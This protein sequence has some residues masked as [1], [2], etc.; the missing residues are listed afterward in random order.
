M[1]DERRGHAEF[2]RRR[3][4]LA[5]ATAL[6]GIAALNLTTPGQTTTKTGAG[7]GA[8][9]GARR[10]TLHIVGH[11]HIDAA[12]LWPWRDGSNVVL[13]TIR[14]ALDRMRETPDFRYSHSSTAHYEWVER[15]DPAMFAEI[16]ERV[17]EGRWELVGGWPVEPD[18]NIP[19]TESLVRHC[20]YGKSYFQRAFGVDVQIGFN[21]DSF[22][23]PAG[24]PSILRRAG[25]RYYVF[26]RPQEHELKLPLLFWWE[27]PDGSR[28]LALRIRRGYSEPAHR[29]RLAAENNFQEGF[30][31][32]AFFLGVGNHGGSV[33]KEQIRQVAEM[34]GDATL[35]EL[36]WS[37]VGEFFKAVE[38]SPA[39]AALP[40]V[41]TELQYHS[42]GVYS[43]HG[44]IKQTN[45][46][47]ERWL[48]QAEAISL[49]AAIGIG[50]RYPSAEYA[51]AWGKVL[52][53]QFH[54]LMAGTAQYVAYRDARDQLGAACDTALTN[55]VEA[56]EAMARRVDTRAVKEGAV[57]AFNP[58]PWPRKCLVE[59]HTERNPGSNP[60][61]PVPAGVVPVTHLEAKD[62]QK[63]PLQFRPSDSMTQVYPRITAWVDLPACGYK[64]FEVAHGTPPETAPYRNFF[65]VNEEGFGISSLKATDG[66]ELLAGPIGLVVIGDPSDT[67][68]HGV[69]K[70][71]AEA[72]RPTFVSTQQVEDGPVTRVIRQRARWRNSEVVLDI[73]QFKAIDAIELRF[74][75]DWHERE[76][77]LKLEVPTAFASP[78]VFAKVPGAAVERPPDG[79]EQP[80]QDWVAVAGRI[81]GNEH[82]LGLIN[83]STYSYDCKGGLLRTILIRAAP[84]ARH[85]PHQVPHNDNGAWQDQGRQERR[86]WLVRGP[87]AFTALELDRLSDEMQTPAEYVMD[88]AHGGSEPW[89]RSF[90]RLSPGNV[91]LLSL[92]RAEGGEGS[93]VRVQER[94][95]R[96]TEFTLESATLG[97]SH[98]AQI[99][100]WEI[101]TFLLT[102]AR[103]ARAQVREV[104]LLE[105]PERA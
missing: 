90:F 27:S 43:A 49:A 1:V 9:G 30:D 81:G 71:R 10:K 8:R 6:G 5:G 37:T 51:A 12:W 94:A 93:I 35:P 26:M 74:V 28:V 45:R 39:A 24:L 32:A 87:G 62:G 105:R 65:S 89:E 3:F 21:P 58:L 20:L 48:G 46:R 40:V 52:F 73:A 79:D 66:T 69:T 13:T 53:N 72:G 95:G 84:F 68:G 23:H 85:D 76:Q 96:A 25:Y 47:A 36:R 92:K 34:R 19:S 4:L 91:A 17:R 78:R 55:T 54:D 42:R 29:L 97:T 16:K 86:F 41:S 64:V 50:H 60:W 15:A 83:N 98:R 103:G 57:F 59:Y 75:I 70:Y 7:V 31:H 104:N 33:T 61:I 22:G 80:Y 44:E 11:S 14:S 18:C 100:P 77:I 101:K 102:G 99:N 63:I 88:S 2:S 56:L 67:W 38:A 82:T